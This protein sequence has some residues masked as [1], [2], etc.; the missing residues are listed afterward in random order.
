VD[1]KLSGEIDRYFYSFSV[2]NLLDRTYFNYGLDEGFGF[3]QF[4]PLP[5]R[6]FM[7]K[8]GVTF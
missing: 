2:Q 5:G 7:V 8:A 1:V 4:Y 6:T 3:Y